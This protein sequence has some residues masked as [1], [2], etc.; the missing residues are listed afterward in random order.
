MDGVCGASDPALRSFS[1][2]GPSSRR[3]LPCDCPL[4]VGSLGLKHGPLSAYPLA[5]ALKNPLCPP[6][7]RSCTLPRTFRGQVLGRRAAASRGGTLG[8]SFPPNL[9]HTAFSKCYQPAMQ[10]GFVSK[11][12]KLEP[13]TSS[14]GNHQNKRLDSYPGCFLCGL[15]SAPSGIR[16]SPSI[17]RSAKTLIVRFPSFVR[18]EITRPSQGVKPLSAP[19]RL[20]TPWAISIS[21]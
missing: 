6:P 10:V 18:A 4:E 13:Y 11:V 20:P 3:S 16:R 14:A 8:V 7:S 12:V 5:P 15:V 9:G 1:A 17:S 19:S 2:N 21:K